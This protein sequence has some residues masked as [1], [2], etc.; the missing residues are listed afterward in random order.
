M[1]RLAPLVVVIGDICAVLK[2]YPST[3]IS[4]YTVDFSVSSA[5]GTELTKQTVT[6][7]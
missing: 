6:I 5:D 7:K 3:S 1:Q 4:N 2:V